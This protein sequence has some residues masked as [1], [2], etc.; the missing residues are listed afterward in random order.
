MGGEMARPS[1]D[2]LRGAEQMLADSVVG[3]RCEVEFL[4]LY[5]DQPLFYEI[6]GFLLRRGFFL[7]RLEKTGTG[8]WGPST[9][10]GPFSLSLEDAAPAWADAIFLKRS[11]LLF[12]APLGP[13][14]GTRLA[15]LVLFGMRNAIGSMGLDAALRLAKEGRLVAVLETLAVGERAR[16]IGL[17]QDYLSQAE[18]ADW[19]TERHYQEWFKRDRVLLREHLLRA[20]RQAPG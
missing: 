7:A 8:A 2:V 3:V 4:A 17:L 11:D 10:A 1:V 18:A 19:Q 14:A 6:M 20:G 16:L 9:D 12:A 13:T 15:R 5:R